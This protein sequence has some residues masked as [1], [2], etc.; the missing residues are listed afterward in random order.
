MPY[1]RTGGKRERAERSSRD[2]LLTEITDGQNERMAYLGVNENE[3][4]IAIR[5]K[6]SKCGNT[7]TVFVTSN[8]K[9]YIENEPYEL[10]IYFQIASK[11]I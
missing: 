3:E 10:G 9:L 7:R 4:N 6:V 1:T 5:L 8:R 11:N 2:Q